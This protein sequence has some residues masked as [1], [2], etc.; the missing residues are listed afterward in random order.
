MP[1]LIALL[2]AVCFHIVTLSSYPTV[3]VDEVWLI[4][5]AW[6]WLRTGVNFGP[7]DAGVFD[8]QLEGYGTFFPIIPTLLLSVFVHWFGLAMRWLRLLP[9]LCGF[10]LLVASFSIAH[11]SSASKRCGLIAALLVATSHSF[12]ISAHLVRYDIFVAVLG[13][14]SLAVALSA[15]CQRRSSLFF[16]SGLMISLAFEVHVNAVLFGPM[17]LIVMVAQGGWGIVRSSQLLGLICGVLCGIGIYVLLHV[18]PYP[19]TFVAM[20]KGLATTHLPPLFSPNLEQFWNSIDETSRYWIYLT[21]GRIFITVLAACTLY[22][23]NSQNTKILFLMLIVS[24][25]TFSLLIRNKMFY[26]AILITPLS[27]IFLAVWLQEMS[28]LDTQLSFW[29]KRLKAFVIST[30][31]ATCGIPVYLV[32]SSPSPADLEF[33]ENRIKQAIP[34]NASIMGPQTYWLELYDHQYFSWQQIL[35]HDVLNSTDSVEAALVAL[36]PNILIIDDDMRQ[37][38]LSN[39]IEALRSG[40]ERYTWERRI[41]KEELEGFLTQHAD[42]LDDF[43]STS[44]GRIQ[45]FLI[46]WNSLK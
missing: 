38:I 11:Q 46:R 26:Y 29:L 7:L 31:I 20:G 1:L 22:W 30:L 4:S 40:F 2:A 36:H 35:V 33:T 18:V 21:S 12:L 15:W 13:Y 24:L 14:S 28:R 23:W 25:I 44:Y 6:A 8:K 43:V 32:F 9:L 27:D 41:S 10:G 5:R 45:I 39:N 42:L 37:Y 17:I 34:A 3:F 16:I 19:T